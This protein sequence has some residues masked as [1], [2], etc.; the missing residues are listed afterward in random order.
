MNCLVTGNL[1]L[2]HG[3][4]KSTFGTFWP[5]IFH[6]LELILARKLIKVA[7]R[8]ANLVPVRRV[9]RN[10]IRAVLALPIDDV[11]CQTL[12]LQSWIIAISYTHQFL[13]QLLFSDL[14][15]VNKLLQ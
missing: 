13:Y 12:L 10:S 15:A 4:A 14:F 6:L 2:L 3:G 11:L 5:F 8:V 9:P 7:I 1:A